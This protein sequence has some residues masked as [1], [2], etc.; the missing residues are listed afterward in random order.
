MR[1]R[2]EV[3]LKENEELRRINQELEI[4]NVEYKEIISLQAEYEDEYSKY[5]PN[6]SD[7]K[8]ALLAEQVQKLHK[9]NSMLTGKNFIQS[10]T[11]LNLT[12]QLDEFMKKSN[13]VDQIVST[14]GVLGS[15]D[16]QTAERPRDE[17]SM[18]SKNW[19]QI[20]GSEPRNRRL[21]YKA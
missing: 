7:K 19:T 11:I 12:N 3:L 8:L 10:L 4:E 13:L 16:M 1:E 14:G 18:G 5:I 6:E 20:I 2:I 9:Q 15:D 21:S 17:V